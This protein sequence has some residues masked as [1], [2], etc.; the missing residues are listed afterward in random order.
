MVDVGADKGA[1]VVYTTEDLVGREI[2]IRPRGTAWAGT[3]TA[4]REREVGATVLHAGVFGSLTA[5]PY[6]L[7]VKTAS[8]EGGPAVTTV[9]V[10]AGAVVEAHLDPGGD[11]P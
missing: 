8:E 4:V 9:T 7:R 2:E 10:A 6:D 3:H 1:L 11:R 5:G